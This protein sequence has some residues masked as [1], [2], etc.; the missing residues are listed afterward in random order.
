MEFKKEE[1]LRL[2][3][4]SSEKLNEMNY[5]FYKHWHINWDEVRALRDELNNFLKDE[6]GTLENK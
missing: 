4:K 1:A 2:I 6:N 3:Q 5:H